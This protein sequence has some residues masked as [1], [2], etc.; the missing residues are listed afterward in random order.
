MLTKLLLGLIYLAAFFMPYIL[1]PMF[2]PLSLRLSDAYHL[3]Y[4]DLFRKSVEK[5][6][7]LVLDDESYGV[8]YL[9]PLALGFLKHAAIPFAG[10]NPPAASCRRF[11]P[12]LLST[13]S[14]ANSSTSSSLQP[15][16]TS[17]AFSAAQPAC[18]HPSTAAPL[19]PATEP[20][21]PPS[22]HSDGLDNLM[23]V[24]QVPGQVFSRKSFYT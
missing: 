10:D 19:S 4:L 21:Y 23:A 1:L 12:P 8:F 6:E 17:S 20:F 18:L 22:R 16:T 5:H 9:G 14:Q 2:A 7:E 24:C 3:L 15:H 11:K 13:F